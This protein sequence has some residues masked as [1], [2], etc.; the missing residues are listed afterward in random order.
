MAESIKIKDNVFIDTK[1]IVHNKNLLSHI[2]LKAEYQNNW[3][4]IHTIKFNSVDYKPNFVILRWNGDNTIGIY[5]VYA[6]RVI[7]VL[8]NGNGTC[9]YTIDV[10]N[11]TVTFTLSNTGICAYIECP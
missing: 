1:G 8:K 7:E 3:E 2:L 6:N 5:C 11:K 4:L 10:N 9:T